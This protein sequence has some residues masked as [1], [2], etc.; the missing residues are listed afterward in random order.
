VRRLLVLLGVLALL[1]AGILLDRA[2]TRDGDTVAAIGDSIMLWGEPEMRTTVGA[3]TR[4]TVRAQ[5]GKR[6]DEM[7]PA[8]R[9]LAA[10]SPV[11]VI[12]NLGTNDVL[13]RIPLEESVRHLNDMVGL[14]PQAECIHLVTINENI[15]KDGFQP[16]DA[17]VALNGA[18]QQLAKDNP[19]V[20][21]IRW[22]EMVRKS[23]QREPPTGFIFDGVHPGPEGQ[24]ALAEA[25]D[26]AVDRC[27]R[28]WK[29]W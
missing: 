26:R 7:M 4:L 5:G 10:T 13:Q 8:A 27:G 3:H 22:D 12:I 24:R 20:S 6:I 21:L 19:R 23:I 11:Q 25:Y 1:L 29:F 2:T 16:H 9:E 18:M 17:A 14:Y 15:D 28:P